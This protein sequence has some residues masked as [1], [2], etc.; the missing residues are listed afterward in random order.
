MHHNVGIELSG[1]K[2]PGIYKVL[3]LASLIFTF[4]TS[5]IILFLENT[6]PSF[7]ASTCQLTAATSAVKINRIV[8]RIT[9]MQFYRPL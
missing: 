2:F 4:M 7:K 1:L 6:K 9:E 8:Y 3:V 5:S